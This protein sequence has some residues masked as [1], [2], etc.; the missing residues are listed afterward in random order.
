MSKFFLRTQT[1]VVE[2]K[3]VAVDSSG[4]EDSAVFGWKRH[5]YQEGL[6]L[7]K[8]WFTLATGAKSDSE[9]INNPKVTGFVWKHV[10]YIKGLELVDDKGAVMLRI[11]DTRTAGDSPDL[12]GKESDCLSWISSAMQQSSPWWSAITSS[13]VDS[14]TNQQSE[15]GVKNSKR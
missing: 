5:S 11:E 7:L 1:P 3:V 6:D 14:F 4:M 15:T 10:L 13:L 9:M 12:W 2:L 8:E